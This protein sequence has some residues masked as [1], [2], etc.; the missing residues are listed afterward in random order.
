MTALGP[1]VSKLHAYLGEISLISIEKMS[2]A[3]MTLSEIKVIW[4]M[5]V[6]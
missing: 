3:A 2:V 6:W 4:L 5:Y 1:V